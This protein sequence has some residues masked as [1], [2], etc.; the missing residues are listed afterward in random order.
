MS[1]GHTRL[2]NFKTECMDRDGKVSWAGG[3]F[4]FVCPPDVDRVAQVKW[5][6]C[7]QPVILSSDIHIFKSRSLIENNFRDGSA[8]I[9][10]AMGKDYLVNLFSAEVRSDFK[11]NSGKEH[12]QSIIAAIVAK[13]NDQAAAVEAKKVKVIEEHKSATRISRK[14]QGPPLSAPA[15]GVIT[16]DDA[17]GVS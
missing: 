15:R 8:Y 5:R 7:T 16:S 1:H 14:R 10:G 12:H 2:T 9:K 3:A 17:G 11:R 4:S 6:F 13:A